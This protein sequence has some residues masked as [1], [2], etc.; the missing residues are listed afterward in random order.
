[1]NDE[2]FFGRRKWLELSMNTIAILIA[3]LVLLSI[4]LV[5]LLVPVPRSCEKYPDAL[6]I[7]PQ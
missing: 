7:P 2:S 3:L 4:L 6:Q 5:L 1:V